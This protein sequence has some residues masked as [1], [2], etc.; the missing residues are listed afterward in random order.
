[1]SAINELGDKNEPI[2]VL[3]TLCE[4]FD[5]LDFTGPMELLKSARHN[6]KD[7]CTL[8]PQSSTS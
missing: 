1:M 5:T 8:F 4:G 7:P 2:N 3:F 6:M